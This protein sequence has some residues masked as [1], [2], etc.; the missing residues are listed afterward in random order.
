MTHFFLEWAVRERMREL[1]EVDRTLERWGWFLRGRHTLESP[2]WRFRL[3]TA[4]VRAGSWLQGAQESQQS[5][6]G[7][8]PFPRTPSGCGGRKGW[9]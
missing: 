1:E 3:G 8:I 9:G 6:D 4:L 7:G 2:T 5:R